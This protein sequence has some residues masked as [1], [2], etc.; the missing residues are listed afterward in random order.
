MTLYILQRVAQ[1]HGLILVDTKYEFGKGPDGSVL[2]IDEV[3]SIKTKPA[4]DAYDTK[5]RLFFNFS[6]LIRFRCIHLTQVDIGLPVHTRNASKM[7]LNL[8]ILT[9]SGPT[10]FESDIVVLI[11]Q[12]C[13]KLA[14]SYSY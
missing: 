1:E 11:I 10:S 6:P 7:V 2:L 4:S 8:K 14:K 13:F 12:L 5:L 3:D 9:R